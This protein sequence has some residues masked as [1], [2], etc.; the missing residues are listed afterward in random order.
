VLTFH[1]AQI[2][3]RT[4]VAASTG[5]HEHPGVVGLMDRLG[6]IPH[7]LKVE[8]VTALGTVDGEKGDLTLAL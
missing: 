4:E 6:E 7:R 8:C 5:D 2:G 3:A 1:A